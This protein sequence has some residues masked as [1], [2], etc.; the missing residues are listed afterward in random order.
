M[1]LE[2]INK[3]KLK[4]IYKEKLDSFIKDL[5]I[6]IKKNIEDGSKKTK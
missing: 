1:G 6:D 5:D 4:T 3:Y 2:D